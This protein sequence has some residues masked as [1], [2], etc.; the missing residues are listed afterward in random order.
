MAPP[1]TFEIYMRNMH[2]NNSNLGA[3]SASPNVVQSTFQINS[4][5]NNKEPT[6]PKEVANNQP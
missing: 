3:L 2:Q 4:S 6:S 1:T 5:N